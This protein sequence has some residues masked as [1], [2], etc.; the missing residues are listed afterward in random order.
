MN[1]L[2]VRQN[3]VIDS[4]FS[5]GFDKHKALIDAGYK[6]K[7]INQAVYSFYNNPKI[8]DEIRK[9]TERISAQCDFTVLQIQKE[10][11]KNHLLAI[12]EKKIADSNSALRLLGQ[13]IGAFTEKVEI[14]DTASLSDI[15]KKVERMELEGIKTVNSGESKPK[16]EGVDPIRPH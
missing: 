4:Y 15:L 3:S 9:R 5:N 8:A 16:V 7:N 11:W 1:N 13:T 10:L 14:N 6:E 12:E 2:S